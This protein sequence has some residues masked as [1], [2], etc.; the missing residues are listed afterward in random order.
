MSLR[1]LR[2]ATSYNRA[3]EGIDGVEVWS[4][5]LDELHRREQVVIEWTGA[6]DSSNAS[7]VVFHSAF[8]V[9]RDICLGVSNDKSLTAKG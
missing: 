4:T 9:A 8:K 7:A 6:E 2:R 1:A 5:A 3:P